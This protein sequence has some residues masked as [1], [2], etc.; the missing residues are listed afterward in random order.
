M[1]LP[2]QLGQ[3]FQLVD[4]LYDNPSYPIGMTVDEC[5]IHSRDVAGIHEL[6]LCSGPSFV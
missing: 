1:R 4:Q 3:I 2:K 5:W 6:L